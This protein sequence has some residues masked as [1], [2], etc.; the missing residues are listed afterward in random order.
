[1][2]ILKFHGNHVCAM[3]QSPYELHLFSRFCAAQEATKIG[4]NIYLLLDAVSHS[5]IVHSPLT[6][7]P[8]DQMKDQP[9]CKFGNCKS[10]WKSPILEVQVVLHLHNGTRLPLYN[11]GDYVIIVITPIV[12]VQRQ[13]ASCGGFPS[14]KCLC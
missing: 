13:G 1:M 7:D 3:N 6:F 5:F 8:I 4:R 14:P 9:K 10:M 11:T 2:H 12:V